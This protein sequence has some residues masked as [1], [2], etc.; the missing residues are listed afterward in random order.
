MLWNM[1]CSS[2]EASCALSSLMPVCM[3]FERSTLR[4]VSLQN[5]RPP[6]EC[7]SNT[8]CASA[9][10]DW[11]KEVLCLWQEKI[12][13]TQDICFSGSYLIAVLNMKTLKKTFSPYPLPSKI[14]SLDKN[15]GLGLGGGREWTQLLN[16]RSCSL[17]LPFMQHPRFNKSIIFESHC[18]VARDVWVCFRFF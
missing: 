12:G 1:T 15:G 18:G 14:G 6:P 4:L 7:P 8:P 13:T 17:M 9:F 3:G 11:G 10:G 16:F 2:T 5:W